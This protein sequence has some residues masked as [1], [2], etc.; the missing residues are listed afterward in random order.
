DHA[1]FVME[2]LRDAWLGW[3]RGVM[4]HM[5][6]SGA[7][8]YISLS[9]VGL[10]FAIVFAVLTALLVVIPYLGVIVGAV[11][12]VLFALTDSPEKA[13]LVLAVYVGVHEMEAN[14]IIP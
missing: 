1:F 4:I 5:L 12:P 13:L 7:L 8:L 3:M 2:R 6:L 14:L 10:Q 11:P 9:I